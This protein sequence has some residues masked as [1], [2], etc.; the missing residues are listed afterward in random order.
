MCIVGVG[1][2]V[3]VFLVVGCGVCLGCEI[4]DLVMCFFGLM[5][6]GVGVFGGV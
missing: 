6:F 4:Y 2:L 3:M 5:I 1:D